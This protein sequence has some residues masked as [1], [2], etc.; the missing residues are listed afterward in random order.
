M[1]KSLKHAKKLC[2][3]FSTWNIPL[4][5]TTGQKFLEEV[6]YAHKVCAYLLKNTVIIILWNI[7]TI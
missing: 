2:S 7:I 5:H 1:T 6:S 3:C 4:L